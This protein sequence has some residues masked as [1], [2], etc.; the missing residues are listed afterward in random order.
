MNAETVRSSCRALDELAARQV[1][2]RQ[3]MKISLAAAQESGAT[4]AQLMEWTGYSRRQVFN[5]LEA[6][7]SK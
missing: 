6:A 7:R 4:I 2:A 3:Q 5:L 1:E